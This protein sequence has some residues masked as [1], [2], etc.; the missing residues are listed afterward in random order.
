MKRQHSL[1]ATFDQLL[2]TL[3]VGMQGTG[4]TTAARLMVLQHALA[5]GQVVIFDAYNDLA[6]EMSRYFPDCYSEAED[7]EAHA[8]SLLQEVE[9]RIK[10]Y[11]TG[12]RTF[13]PLLI[14]VDEL[15]QYEQACPSLVALLQKGNDVCRKARMRFFLAGTRFPASSVGGQ[16]AKNNTA[17]VF[18]FKTMNGDLLSDF[19]IVGE[20]QKRLQK[21]LFA[22][23]SGYCV[24][25]SLPLGIEGKLLKLPNI[26]AQVFKRELKGASL[27]AVASP[28]QEESAT[29]ASPVSLSPEVVP[30][31][32][33]PP[34]PLKETRE[35]RAAARVTPRE[36]E[37]IL[38]LHAQGKSKT[39][40]ALQLGHSGNWGARVEQVL[41]EEGLLA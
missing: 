41:K 36:R 6:Q 24:V 1:Y 16:F 9:R 23:P 2:V 5:G 14:V 31:P 12:E 8:A 37:E 39:S 19:G 17:N 20:D 34:L 21:A 35:T 30:L 22:A 29:S 32:T 3:A 4:K 33:L 28:V 25:R 7:V 11:R 10:A 26:T 40:I 38:Y 27:V 18:V 15:P 13:T